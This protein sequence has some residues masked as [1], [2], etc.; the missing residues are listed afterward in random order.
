MRGKYAGTS[1]RAPRYVDSKNIEYDS[2]GNALVKDVSEWLP[3]GYKVPPIG[4]FGMHSKEN[5]NEWR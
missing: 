5:L 1:N 4:R 2:A 3:A